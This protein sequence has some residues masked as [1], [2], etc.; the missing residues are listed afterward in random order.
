ML[1]PFSLGALFPRVSKTAFHHGLLEQDKRAWALGPAV[2]RQDPFKTSEAVALLFLFLAAPSSSYPKIKTPND[3]EMY[4]L[5]Y[6]PAHSLAVREILNLGLL[7]S[8][9][10]RSSL[11][12]C[13]CPGMEIHLAGQ[14]CCTW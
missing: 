5:R 11:S 4:I 1:E 8:S 13:L 14:G 12:I 7:G 6:I 2:L 3:R 9:E 10:Q